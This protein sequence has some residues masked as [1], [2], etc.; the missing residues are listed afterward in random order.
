MRIFIIGFMGSGKS[1][2]GKRLAEKMNMDFIDL[3]KYIEDQEGK[4]IREIFATEGEDYFR[5][6]E[7]RCLIEMKNFENTIIA[8]GGGTPCF[9]QNMDWMNEN[10]KT[11]FLE[12]PVKILA[13]RLEKAME[14]RPLLHGFSKKELRIFIEKK[15][16]E[17]NP[18]YRKSKIIFKQ[19]E[20]GMELASSL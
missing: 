5:K 13:N 1:F 19:D 18:F 7:Q 6:T 3:D 11:I 9:F 20:E 16:E 14:N 8:V 15:L 10:G 4:T 12:T 17:R 2:S